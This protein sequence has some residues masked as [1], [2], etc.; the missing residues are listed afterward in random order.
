MANMLAVAGPNSKYSLGGE[1]AGFIAGL[2]H[3]L[4]LPITFVVGWFNPGVRVY[5]A[6]NNGIGYEFG[7]IMGITG[8][9]GGTG[10]A[11]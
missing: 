7:F 10:S 6:N 8:S 5:E 2:W 9:V 11:T 4:I 3:G 1:P